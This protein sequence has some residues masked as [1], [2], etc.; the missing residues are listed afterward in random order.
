MKQP[1]NID[2]V[3]KE[4][5]RTYDSSLQEIAL[6][7][8]GEFLQNFPMNKL[9]D[10][11]L[12]E[13][14]IG[15]QSPTFCT[16]VE[17]KTKPWAFIQGATADK[18]GIYFGVTNTDKTKKYRFTKKFGSDEQSAFNSVKKALLQLIELGKATELDFQ[19]IDS[20]P[21]SQMFKAKILS[22][23]FPD[24]FI[25]VCSE[26]HLQLFGEKYGHG[27][28]RQNSEYQ[29]LLLKSKL[30]NPI[31]RNW[32]NPKF[33]AFLYECFNNQHPPKASLQEP[34]S[35]TYKEVDFEKLN[36]ERAE[37]GELAEAF[38]Y[39]WEKTRLIGADF[40]E[41]IPKIK[42]HRKKPGYG[43]DF[44]SYSSSD[45][46]RCIEVKSVRKLFKGKKNDYRFFLSA[47]QYETSHIERMKNNY[48]FYLVFF[49]GQ[50]KPVYLKP[51]IA[52]KFYNDVEIT[53]T[54]YLISF[55]LSENLC[56]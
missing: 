19:A 36:R 31:T 52:N 30:S 40:K 5:D 37:I 12:D 11:T 6:N 44:L 14:V 4:W 49:D 24:K 1:P 53:P 38:A 15:Q 45:E 39:E 43:Y 8:R 21:I 10:M 54:N 22:L 32:S 7:T 47:N 28:K 2:N 51:V 55:N 26:E 50:G 34:K 27:D 33:T 9:K 41:L 23:Y 13:Y 35:K 18:F 48:Y 17:V 3:L 16:F 46:K 56:S 42:D 25:N 29:H 20:N